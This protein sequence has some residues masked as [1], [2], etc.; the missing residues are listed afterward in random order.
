[1]RHRPGPE[2]RFRAWR[3]EELLN[4]KATRP[5][6]AGHIPGDHRQAGWIIASASIPTRWAMVNLAADNLIGFLV[7]GKPVTPLNHE[8]T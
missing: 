6:L 2:T 5:D 4:G 3:R 8:A 7:H 1:M